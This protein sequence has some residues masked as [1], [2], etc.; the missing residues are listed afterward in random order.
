MRRGEVI[1]FIRIS[2]YAFWKL[3]N[4]SSI[5]LLN[6]LL[7]IIQI[8]NVLPLCAGK[9]KHKFIDVDQACEVHVNWTSVCISK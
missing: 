4:G 7:N 3:V 2:L 9:Y 5:L 6:L 8:L 1:F